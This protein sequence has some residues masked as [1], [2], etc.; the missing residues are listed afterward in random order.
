[1]LWTRCPEADQRIRRMLASY[2]RAQ[3][4]GS[5]PYRHPLT[6]FTG[7]SELEF[8]IWAL[9]GLVSY[10]TLR[11]MHIEHQ[12]AGWLDTQAAM[13]SPLIASR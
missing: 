2:A 8:E 10:R 3:V 6:E 5:P 7:L 1:M 13:L 11:L 9:R 12:D 4:H